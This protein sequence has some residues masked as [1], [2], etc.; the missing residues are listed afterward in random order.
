MDLSSVLK[1]I[2]STLAVFAAGGIG[3]LFTFRAIPTWYAGLKKPR[4][5][6]PN[7]AFGPVWTTLYV[8]MVISVF[9]LWQGGLDT[10]SELLLATLSS[11]RLSR[12]RFPALSF[13][14]GLSQNIFSRSHDPLSGTG[15]VQQ[16][17][18]IAARFARAI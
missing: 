5:T 7:W 3:S 14:R 10:K 16:M 13:V 12:R 2:V 18:Q 8:L 1:L 9:L 11:S 17:V 15:L 6:P 4:Y